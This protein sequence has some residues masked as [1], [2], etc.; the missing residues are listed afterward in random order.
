M[1]ELLHRTFSKSLSISAKN[2]LYISL[3]RSQLIYGSPIWRPYLIKDIKL[4]EQIQ[5]RATKFIL[6]DFHS[7][8][9]NCLVKLQFLPIMYMFELYDVMFLVKSLKNPSPCFHITDYISFSHFS[10][11]AHLLTSYSIIIHVTTILR[12]FILIDYPTFG[13]AYPLLI[14][15]YPPQLLRPNFTKFFGITFCSIFNQITHA[16]FILYVLVVNAQ[17]P[18]TPLLIDDYLNMYIRS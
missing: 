4:I 15:H 10:T 18:L 6:N 1:L 3:V 16:L 7:D 8:Y 11:E 5:R 9:Y 17:T 13:I 12:I 2:L 14:C